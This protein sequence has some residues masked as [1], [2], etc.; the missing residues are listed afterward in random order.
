MRTADVEAIA[1]E[2]VELRE[3]LRA[4]TKERDD[5]RTLVAWVGD[6]DHDIDETGSRFYLWDLSGADALM[7]ERGWL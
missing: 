4:V 5:L 3:Q 2:I 7:R 1:R 6:Y